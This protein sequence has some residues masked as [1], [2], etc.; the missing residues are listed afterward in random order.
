MKPVTVHV[1][2]AVI[3]YDADA[4]PAGLTT[5]EALPRLFDA[6]WWSAQGAVTGDAPGRGSALFLATEVGEA[7]LRRYLRGGMVAKVSH[8]RYVFRGVEASRPF[9][10]FDVLARMA[11]D[12]LPVPEPLAAVCQR[13]GLFY[14]AALLTRRIAPARALPEHFTNPDFDWRRLGVELRR[15][16]DAG[17]RHA[18]LNA[19]NL[20]VHDD[21]NAAWV[22]DLDASRYDPGRPAGGE[23]QLARLHR[24]LEKL[25]PDDAPSLD[26]CWG[27]LVAGS[28]AAGAATPEGTG[29]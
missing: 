24:S 26:A 20:L 23:R 13:E 8:D 15:L 17:M 21:T 1:E 22:I 5:P 14:R 3:V 19:R 10:E 16:F 2:N 6:D 7:V 28:Q 25:W 4:L 11:D 29:S 12:G 9:R 18:D 27:A